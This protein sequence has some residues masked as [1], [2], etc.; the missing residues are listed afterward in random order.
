MHGYYLV[1]ICTCDSTSAPVT[2]CAAAGM[3]VVIFTPWCISRGAA[4]QLRVQHLA[5]VTHPSCPA[6][7]GQRHHLSLL[8][9]WR[10]M[11]RSL[12][13]VGREIQSCHEGIH[14]HAWE[15]AECIDFKV[16]FCNRK[17]RGSFFPRQH[18]NRL[19]LALR[20]RGSSFSDAGVLAHSDLSWISVHLFPPLSTDEDQKMNLASSEIHSPRYIF[21]VFVYNTYPTYFFCVKSRKV[22]S[23]KIFL[24][25][26]LHAQNRDWGGGIYVL[27]FFFF[28]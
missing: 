5:C 21:F 24:N 4:A 23:V 18:W 3:Y 17:V 1:C 6:L 15:H 7:T 26:H 10:Q 11:K 9:W 27:W 14:S 28:F 20:G 8:Y 25:N 16:W 2:C 12:C 13:R 22:I 19:S